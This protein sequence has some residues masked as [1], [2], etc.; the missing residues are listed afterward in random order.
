MLALILLLVSG[1]FSREH[2]HCYAYPNGL[3]AYVYAY[4]FVAG[5][6][7]LPYNKPIWRKHNSAYVQYKRDR[8]KHK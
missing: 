4:A 3:C 7:K 5:Q 8:H 1:P 6:S 2:K